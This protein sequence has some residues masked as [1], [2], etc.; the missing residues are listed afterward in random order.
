MLIQFLDGLSVKIQGVLHLGGHHG[1][2][3]PYYR[4]KGIDHVVFCEA[5]PTLIP[6]LSRNCG[7]DP[8]IKIFN[9]AVSDSNGTLPF[10][11]T[12]NSQSSSILPLHDHLKSYPQIT[13][14]HTMM[15]PSKRVDDLLSENSLDPKQY[16]CLNMDIQGAELIALRG[17]P[18]YLQHC[19][20]VYTEV[21][22]REMYRGCALIG[23]LEE[24]LSKYGFKRSRIVDTNAGW[25]DALYLKS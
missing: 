14:L 16:N 6:V 10:H 23:E 17:M 1:E 19:D 8:R 4:S 15:V 21:N 11:I 2:E 13:H 24:E 12:T 3:L 5:N 9:V 22:F 18:E 20:V 25:G 7:N